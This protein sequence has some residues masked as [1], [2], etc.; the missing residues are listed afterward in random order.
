M[1]KEITVT[2]DSGVLSRYQYKEADGD[3]GRFHWWSFRWTRDRV[4]GAR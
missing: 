1:Y 2:S 3:G 4:G